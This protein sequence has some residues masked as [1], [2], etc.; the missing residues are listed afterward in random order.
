MVQPLGCEGEVFP[1]PAQHTPL[2]SKS[3]KCDTRLIGK[4]AIAVETSWPGTLR[5]KASPPTLGQSPL[6]RIV[7]DSLHS[8][9]SSGSTFYLK[10]ASQNHT[11][12]LSSWKECMWMA[13]S[14][15]AYR[16]NPSKERG[17]T[18]HENPFIWEMAFYLREKVY[19]PLHWYPHRSIVVE[20][21]AKK[22][23]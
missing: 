9:G 21:G 22:V 20:K 4:T 12:V 10:Y 13:K 14:H 18:Q 17:G 1:P 15:L 16:L 3:G 11:E 7:A 6:S 5:E 2:F 19:C 8:C 23:F